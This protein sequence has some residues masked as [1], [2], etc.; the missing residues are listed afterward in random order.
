MEQKQTQERPRSIRLTHQA[1]EMIVAVAIFLV[2]VVMMMDGHRVGMG[3]APEGPQAGY[4]PFRTG[5][6]IGI[7]SAVILLRALFG[8][9]R[10]QE[11]FVSWD[12]FKQVLYV[13]IPAAF[14]VLVTQFIGIYVASALFI[15]GFMR[16]MARFSWTKVILV[17]VGISAMLFYMFEIQFMVPLPK[18]PLESLLG[19]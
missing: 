6:I 3:W 4:F 8:K 16:V 5:A 2:G 19:Y 12:R 9:H 11:L 15:G 14:Y 1:A 13:L 7:S 17:G 10:N 18:G